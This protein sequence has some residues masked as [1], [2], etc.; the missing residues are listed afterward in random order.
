M[1]CYP[2]LLPK[3]VI[4]EYRCYEW[5]EY[6]LSTRAAF[7]E[8]RSLTNFE[9]TVRCALSDVRFPIRI[10]IAAMERISI[11]K[12]GAGKGNKGQATF[13]LAGCITT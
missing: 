3:S 8:G 7:F 4:R 6:D 13:A 12:G 1:L 5:F 9:C 11:C 10:V 2:L